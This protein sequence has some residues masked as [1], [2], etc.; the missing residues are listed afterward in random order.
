MELSGRVSMEGGAALP[1][2]GLIIS[3]VN[4]GFSFGSRKIEVR[5][6]G[7]FSTMVTEGEYRITID[8]LPPGYVLKSMTSGPVD[9][10]QSSLKVTASTPSAIVVTISGQPAVR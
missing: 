6:Q 3:R 7:S 8:G 9:L 5:P 10:M 4:G 2:L 1:P